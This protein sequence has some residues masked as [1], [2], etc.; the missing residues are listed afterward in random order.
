[1]KETS[2]TPDVNFK[3]ACVRAPSGAG[4]AFAQP[5]DERLSALAHLK[6]SHDILPSGSLDCTACTQETKQMTGAVRAGTPRAG[7]ATATLGLRTNE[8]N[9]PE[10]R[11]Y[12]EV[13]KRQKCKC[14]QDCCQPTAPNRHWLYSGL[15]DK[16]VHSSYG[17]N[18][19]VLCTYTG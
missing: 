11:V 7:A 13:S 15:A 4:V 8:H 5:G 2:H 14:P 16:W 1:M 3:V 10:L 9:A 12:L 17:L 6:L 19:M 18:R